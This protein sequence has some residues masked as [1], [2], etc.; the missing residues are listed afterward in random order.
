MKKNLIFILLFINSIIIS[1]CIVQ[2]WNFQNSAIDLL[3][4]SDTAS[5][6]IKVIDETTNNLHVKLYKYL[7]KGAVVYKKYLTVNYNNVSLFH[8]EV[9]FDKI[10]SY[11]RFGTDNIICPQGKYHPIYYTNTGYTIAN[12]DSF[13]DNGDWE[14]KC[15]NHEG[16]LFIVFYLMNGESH[17]FYRKTSGDWSNLITYKEIYGVKLS[18]IWKNNYEY[19][20]AYVVRDGDYIKLKGSLFTIKRDGI[21]RNDAGGSI[22]IMQSKTNTRGCFENDND[23]FYFFTYSD[24]SDFSTGYYDASDSF[25]YSSVEQYTSEIN[26][27]EESPLEFMDEVEIEYIKYIYIIINMLIIK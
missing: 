22:T 9:D 26:K 27:N 17:L 13:I 4:E 1:I 19:P 10:E 24:T 25:D 20:L 14:L 16:K 2:N 15:I 18:P 8:D 23:H 3:S 21:K 7:A 5:I 12:I 11:H 6:S